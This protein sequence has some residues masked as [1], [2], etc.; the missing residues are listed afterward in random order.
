MIDVKLLKYPEQLAARLTQMERDIQ[1]A[2]KE[3]LELKKKVGK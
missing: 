2:N 1:K 3:I